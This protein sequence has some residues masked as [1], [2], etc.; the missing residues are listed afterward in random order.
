MT[1]S[2]IPPSTETNAP[3]HHPASEAEEHS[4]IHYMFYAPLIPTEEKEAWEQ[5]AWDNQDWIEQEIKTEFRGDQEQ[6]EQHLQGTGSI[7]REVHAMTPDMLAAFNAWRTDATSS[8]SHDDGHHDAHRDLSSSAQTAAV[9][10]G[11]DDHANEQEYHLPL[12]Q[13]YPAPLD[14]SIVNVDLNT[15]PGIRKTAQDAMEVNHHMLSPVVALDWLFEHTEVNYVY[16][17]RP[18][19]LMVEPV[20]EG[21]GETSKIRGFLMAELEWGA[22][23]SYVLPET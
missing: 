2:H 12:W 13:V 15:H 23:F 9:S 5:Y 10:D 1:L 19:S 6:M 18:R 4:G 22:F 16:D 11:D 21:F 7:S 20:H 17:G 8:H 3:V 14:A